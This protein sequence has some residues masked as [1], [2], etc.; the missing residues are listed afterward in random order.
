[1]PPLVPSIVMLLTAYLLAEC[2]NFFIVGSSLTRGIC[3]VFRQILHGS[4]EIELPEDLKLAAANGL[5]SVGSEVVVG[6]ECEWNGTTVSRFA[7]SPDAVNQEPGTR[8]KVVRLT[9]NR[10]ELRTVLCEECGSRSG[11]AH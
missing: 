8:M 10:I 4:K 2:L 3:R 1:M 11:N 5:L 6:S 9:R 7:V